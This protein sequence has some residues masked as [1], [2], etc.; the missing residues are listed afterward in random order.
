MAETAPYNAVVRLSI[1]DT[2]RRS[3]KA[4]VRAGA[5]ATVVARH[6]PDLVIIGAKRSGTTSLFRDLEQH[7]AMCPL[8]P[9]AR[10]LPLRENQKGVHY[11]DSHYAKGERWYR[12]HFPTSLT[13]RRVRRQVGSVFTAEAS[14]Y[15][16]FHPLAARR[17]AAALPTTTFV[18]LLRDPV[19][20]AVSHWAEQTRNGVETLS[21]RDALDREADRVGDAATQLASAQIDVS[22]AH[23]QQSYAAQ[24]E[25]AGSLRRWLDLV[26]QDRLLVF[27]SEHYYTEPTAVHDAITDR[28]G[29]LRMPASATSVQRNAAQRSS[30]LDADLE[31]RLVERFTPDVIA[32]ADLLDTTPP[33]PRFEQAI[34]S[35]RPDVGE[36]S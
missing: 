27:F 32:V 17:A 1:D 6:Q 34:A 7:P 23:E 10:R 29:A 14:P 30:P 33:W 20:R 9:S 3:A 28:V 36:R 25:Y 21:L 19:E 8:V 2:A 35:A 12:S 11:F 16:L 13:R 15:Y 31:A 18:A 26:G 24:S 22:H 5:L 4:V